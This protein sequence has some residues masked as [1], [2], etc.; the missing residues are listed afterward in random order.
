MSFVYVEKKWA[1]NQQLQ[2]W[3]FLQSLNP[4][5]ETYMDVNIKG[6]KQARFAVVLKINLLKVIFNLTTYF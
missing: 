2:Y 6:T 3:G 5:V 4:V 1:K